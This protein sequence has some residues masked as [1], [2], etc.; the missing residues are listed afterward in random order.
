MAERLRG[1]NYRKH[2]AGLS[3]SHRG[4]ERANLKRI[5]MA[6]FH[7]YYR[8]RTHLLLEMDN[9]NSRAV[10]RSSFGNVIQFPELGGL[11]HHYE[12]IAA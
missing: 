2:P 7:Y 10:Q 6:Y 8:W 1:T 3:G 12:R 11:H 5:L 9:P 4:I